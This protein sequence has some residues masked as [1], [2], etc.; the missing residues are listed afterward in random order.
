MSSAVQ[1]RVHELKRTLDAAAAARDAGEARAAAAEAELGALRPRTEAAERQLAATTEAAA[2]EAGELRAAA[3]EAAAGRDEARAANATAAAAAAARDL[4]LREVRRDAETHAERAA[5]AEE[6]ARSLTA[7]LAT[8]TAQLE[9][10]QAETKALGEV[11]TLGDPYRG[12]AGPFRGRGESRS[13]VVVG[14]E[15]GDEPRPPGCSRNTARD[16]PIPEPPRSIVRPSSI[17]D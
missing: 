10:A 5:A 2:A 3:A 4:A 11:R 17:S 6:Q 14:T 13:L 12:G 1:A 16:A 9:S 7:A 15:G 8:Q